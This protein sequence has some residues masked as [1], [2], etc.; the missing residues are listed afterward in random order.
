M[1]AIRPFS[2]TITAVCRPLLFATLGFSADNTTVSTGS[3]IHLTVSLNK[4]SNNNSIS[5]AFPAVATNYPFSFTVSGDT[6]SSAPAPGT[7]RSNGAA[8]AVLTPSS[9]GNGTVNVTFDNQT[10]SINFSQ[11]LLQQRRP[12][13]RSAR[14]PAALI[15]TVSPRAL[16]YNSRRVMRQELLSPPISRCW[17]MAWLRSVAIPSD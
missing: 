13:W 4:D 11:L 1:V 17:W 16:Q 8:T 5:G 9:T 6:G 7:F 15:F 2:I 12:H 10:D 3:D 14:F